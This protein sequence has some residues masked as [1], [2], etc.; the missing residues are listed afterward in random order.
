MRIDLL[1]L[2]VILRLSGNI[3]ALGLRKDLSRCTVHYDN[4]S[5]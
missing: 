4:V 3:P 1:W 5:A 2:P